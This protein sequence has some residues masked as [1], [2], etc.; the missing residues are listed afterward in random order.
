MT[1]SEAATADSVVLADLEPPVADPAL[2]GV[3]TFLVGSIAL[4]LVLTGYVPAAATGASIPIILAATGIGQ[5][6]AAVWAASRDQNAVASVFGIFTG[7][8]LSYA[9]LVLGLTNDWFG[10]TADDAVGTQKLFLLTWL[11][12]IV[13]LTVASV[14]LPFAFTLLFALIDAALL[15]VFL[16]TANASTSLTAVGGYLVFSF[17]VVGAYL[18]LDSMSRATGGRG[19]PLGRAVLR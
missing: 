4:G 13:L 2:I 3:P 5:L 7:F 17:V 11:A 8:W 14:R 18:F 9:V 16:G 15:F 12:V 10:I 6:V 19:L 1:T